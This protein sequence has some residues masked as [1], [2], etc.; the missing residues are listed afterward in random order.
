MNRATHNS[1]VIFQLNKPNGK[2]GCVLRIDKLQHKPFIGVFRTENRRKV[3]C[4]LDD[5][6]SRMNFISFN[7][8]FYSHNCFTPLNIP[9]EVIYEVKYESWHTN[10]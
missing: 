2:D 6:N 8:E 4:P 1:E 5:K 7:D 10:N 3:F 9:Q